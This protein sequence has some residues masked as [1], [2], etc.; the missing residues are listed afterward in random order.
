MTIIRQPDTE[1]VFV[2]QRAWSR[3]KEGYWAGAELQLS[4]YVFMHACK[5]LVQ[6]KSYDAWQLDSEEE[7]RFARI[8]VGFQSA[9]LHLSF[10]TT[11][12]DGHCGQG[13]TGIFVAQAIVAGTVL[14]A[15]FR[16]FCDCCG[17]LNCKTTS[18]FRT[19]QSLN[20][21]KMCEGRKLNVPYVIIQALFDAIIFSQAIESWGGVVI[22]HSWYG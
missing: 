14:Y 9:A 3:I 20:P 17:I 15:M 16:T 18:H 10:I 1:L 8:R 6:K 22:K 5:N 11:K 4:D 19:I 12:S 21:R 13:R 7:D 2:T